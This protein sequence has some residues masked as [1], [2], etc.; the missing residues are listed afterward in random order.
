MPN[1]PKIASNKY[2]TPQ[3]SP[4]ISPRY[5]VVTN[6]VTS[7]SSSTGGANSSMSNMSTSH[8]VPA[9]ESYN[10]GNG[11]H[12]E[13]QRHHGGVDGGG[14]WWRCKVCHVT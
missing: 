8:S 5:S 1:V 13:Q 4:F 9:P 7:S 3:P 11:P 14:G 2:G 12:C 10:M 6:S